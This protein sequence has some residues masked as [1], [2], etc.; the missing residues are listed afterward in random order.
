MTRGRWRSSLSSEFSDSDFPQTSQLIELQ[1]RRANSEQTCLSGF[2]LSG[3]SCSE[4][5]LCKMSLCLPT[6]A[7]DLLVKPS[8]VA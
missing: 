6:T 8:L 2:T 7:Y 3:M 4:S 1:Q 5:S